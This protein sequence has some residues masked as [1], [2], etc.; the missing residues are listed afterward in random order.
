MQSEPPWKP[1][2]EEGLGGIASNGALSRALQCDRAH[3]PVYQVNYVGPWRFWPSASSCN[4]AAS[5]RSMCMIVTSPTY[6]A[7]L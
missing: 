4:K 5:I 3:A 2:G 1:L 6:W 7:Q